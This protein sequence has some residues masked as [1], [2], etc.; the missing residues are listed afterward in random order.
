M[1]AIGNRLAANSRSLA[2]NPSLMQQFGVPAPLTSIGTLH[3]VTTTRL[4]ELLMAENRHSAIRPALW[5]QAYAM[6]NSKDDLE[7]ITKMQPCP[8]GVLLAS[9]LHP[10][11]MLRR[12]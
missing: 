2:L 6:G 5:R 3:A 4:C 11:G 12:F 7:G 1:C 8:P 9:R 10:R